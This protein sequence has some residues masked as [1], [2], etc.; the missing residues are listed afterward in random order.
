MLVVQ[1]FGGP[2]ASKST[3]ATGVFHEL[4]KLGHNCEYVPEFAKS[5]VWAERHRDLDLQPYITISQWREVAILDGKVDIVITDS[6]I[7]LGCV[8]NTRGDAWFLRTSFVSYM[9]VIAR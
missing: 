7:L 3:T 8:Y 5:L 6:P 4:K 9:M 2:G 1:L